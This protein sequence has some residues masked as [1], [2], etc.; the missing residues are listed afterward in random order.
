MQPIDASWLAEQCGIL[1]RV[2]RGLLLRAGRE[3][4]APEQVRWPQA[5]PAFPDLAALANGAL[6]RREACVEE[7]RPR[8]GVPVGSLCLAVPAPSQS[9]ATWVVALEIADAKAAE[10]ETWIARVRAGMA[11]REALARRERA[12]ARLAGVLDLV[13][14]GLSQPH[15]HDALT[16]IATAL[17]TRL[18]CERVSIGLRRR[19]SV[20]VEAL[21]HSAGFQP[22]ASLL[23][24]L[25]AAMDE[26]CDQDSVL[27][28]PAPPDAP[29]RIDRAH[30]ELLERHGAGAVWSV[31]LASEGEILGALC[32]ERPA[33]SA[34]DPRAL[35]LCEEAAG[36]LGPLLALHRAAEATPFERTRRLLASR[37]GWLSTSRE[38]HWVLSI[39]CAL[40][41]LLAATPGVHRVR[42]EARLEGRIQRAV[43]AGIDGYL[44][45]VEAQPGDVVRRGQLLARLDD[46][47]LETERRQ[48]SSQLDQLHQ[49]QRGALAS[50]DRA[51]LQIVGARLAQAEAQLDLVEANLER[52][53]LVAPLDGAIVRGD[54]RQLLGS[55]VQKGQVLL[56]VAPLDGYRVMLEV[57]ERDI[58]FVHPGQHGRLALAALPGAPL[59]FTV[60]RVTPVAVAAEGSNRFRAEARLEE[61]GASLRPGMAGVA[62]IETGRRVRAWLWTH[63]LFDWLRLGAWRY[64]PWSG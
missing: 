7:R 56:E 55:P 52:T 20:R 34:V 8:P 21:S 16:A 39:A 48:W 26:A 30:E 4:G 46:R 41:V 57:D 33:A 27:V 45:Q 28:H 31:P 5:A 63:A 42:A 29:A 10:A 62:R 22:R 58:A 61:P 9:G 43:V 15:L 54:L 6:T 64:W 3:G 23:R 12:H 1:P 51:Q 13:G 19:G 38:G 36:L 44:V 35:R 32:C 14:A 53:Q 18:E 25:A 24:D 37:L 11:W 40:C 2:L 60:E 49:E 59:A 50:H 47:D 17:A